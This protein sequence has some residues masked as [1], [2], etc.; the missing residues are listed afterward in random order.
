M[1]IYL[2]NLDVT[3][4]E[5]RLGVK[6][7]EDDR[8][9]LEELRINHTDE[10]HNAHGWHCYDIPFV[11]A[12]GCYEVALMWRD[13]L[14]PHAAAMKG[15]AQIS[16]DWDGAPKPDEAYRRKMEGAKA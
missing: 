5:N 16:G 7:S 4:I 3:Q 11:I 14:T 9:K 15:T 2:G 13:I 8:K 10:I 12:C 1:A 6:L